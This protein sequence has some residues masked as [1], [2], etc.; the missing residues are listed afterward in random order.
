MEN[1]H[2]AYLPISL[3]VSS[4]STDPFF[5]IVTLRTMGVP[6]MV[7]NLTSIHEDVGSIPQWLDP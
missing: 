6:A 2:L 4:K 7:T 1:V 3:T 5:A